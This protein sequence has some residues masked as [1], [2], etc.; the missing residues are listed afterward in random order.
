MRRWPLWFASAPSRSRPLASRRRRGGRGRVGRIRLGRRAGLA[1]GS[2]GGLDVHC[3]RPR[4]VVAAARKPDRRAADS[5]GLRLVRRQ[6]RR[7]SL[8]YLYRGPL[9]HC[10]LAYPSG[11]LRSRVARVAVAAGYMAA[12]V[13]PVGRS[14]IATIALA[15]L[16]VAVA[17]EGYRGAVGRERRARI[18]ALQ[19]ASALGFV[20]ACRRGGPARLPGRRC[21]RRRLARLRGGAHGPRCRAA[22]G[23]P[24]RAVG[25]CAGHGSRRRARSRC[26]GHA[27]GRARTRA[28][29]PDAP[30]RLLAP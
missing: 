11:R 18:P 10:V 12:L 9:F 2:C 14:E 4:C 1:S 27:A 15:A 3:V 28:R 30:G 26:F 24:P 13:P 21:E 7:A 20:L 23:A 19:A 25:A 17:F 5:D 29:R 8:V 22:G 6:L 16:L